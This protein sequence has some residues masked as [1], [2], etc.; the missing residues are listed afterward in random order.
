MDYPNYYGIL[1]ASVRYA[2]I[3]DR[4]KILFSEITALS[5]KWGYCSATNGYFA[6]LYDCS[7]SA[8]SQ[9]ISAL[10]NGGFIRCEYVETGTGNQTQRH[11]YPL[12]M[13]GTP[14]STAKAPP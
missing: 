11:I 2:K 1:P 10:T 5:N 13:V 12:A 8:I 14:F 4:A 9:H 7:A 6:E 3:A